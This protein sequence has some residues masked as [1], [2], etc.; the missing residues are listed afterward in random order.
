[1]EVATTGTAPKGMATAAAAGEW[2]GPS[3]LEPHSVPAAGA[4]CGAAAAGTKASAADS[5]TKDATTTVAAGGGADRARWSRPL[6]PQPTR[7]ARSR[8]RAR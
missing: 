5:A 3:P 6:P 7:G 1:L 2:G 8:W 4:E